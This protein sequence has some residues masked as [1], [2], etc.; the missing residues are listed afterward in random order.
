MTF[1]YSGG[2]PV[3]ERTGQEG[4]ENHTFG[5]GFSSG[6]KTSERTTRDREIILS[7]WLQ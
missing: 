4:R 3:S 5:I 7:H 2:E 6:Y 1:G